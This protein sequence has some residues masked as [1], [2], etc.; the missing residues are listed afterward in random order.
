MKINRFPKPTNFPY[1]LR[2]VFY[3]F[4]SLY[5][6]PTYSSFLPITII[7]TNGT[8]SFPHYTQYLPN[9]TPILYITTEDVISP[10][11]ESKGCLKGNGFP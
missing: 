4:T 9:V 7:P 10:L 8:T 11:P 5:I 2:L 3:V 1:L 6:H